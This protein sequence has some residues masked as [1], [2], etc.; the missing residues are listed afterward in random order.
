MLTLE[1]LVEG[2]D[3]L[4]PVSDVAGRV[5]ALVDAQDG[6]MAELA[7]IIRYEPAL[8]ANVLKLANSAYFGLPGKIEDAKQAIV[9]L[10]MRQVVELVLLVTCAK[11]MNAAVDGYGLDK[12]ELWR[13]AVSA[14][15]LANDLARV[16]GLKHGSRIFTGALLKDIGKLVL[17]QYVRAEMASILKRVNDQGVT[18]KEAERQV[19]GFD[20][21]QVGMMIVERWQFPP[22][23][24]CI[25]GHAH[26]PMEAN[27]CFLEAA[28]VYL[29]DEICRQL[30]F[31]CGVDDASYVEDPRVSRSLG[32]HAADIQGVVDLFGSQMD[33]VDA[34]FALG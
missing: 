14:A 16:K 2:I 26:T 33:R 20:H 1:S 15:I 28:V 27:G 4:K 11:T 12:G 31:G 23:L 6:G 3:H 13:N 7:D 30:D 25:I 5:M 34:L 10:G 21:C 8:T 32:L 22:A 19:L 17:N 24:R 9:Y 29:A 18:F